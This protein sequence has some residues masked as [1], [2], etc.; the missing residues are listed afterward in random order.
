[1]YYDALA[2]SS[3]GQILLRVSETGL[4][5]LYFVGQKD[6]PQLPG[7]PEPSVQARDPRAGLRNGKPI[8]SIRVAPKAVEM[9]LLSFDGNDGLILQKGLKL[10]NHDTPKAALSIL[11]QTQTELSQYFQRKRQVFSLPL[12]LSQGTLFQQKIWTA[13]THIPFGDSWSYGQLAKF[14]GFDSG[15]GRAA[16]AAVG[17]NPVTIIVPCHRVVAANRQLNGYSGGL[18]RKLA[19]LQHEGLILAT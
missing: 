8:R 5:G 14:A 16:G 17:A 19:L 4:A 6:C 7:L 18:S 1:M 11:E 10:V 3:L 2:E 15:Y 9:D 12:D 13:L